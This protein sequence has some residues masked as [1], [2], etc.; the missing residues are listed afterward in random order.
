VAQGA[1]VAVLEPLLVVQFLLQE[2]L[3]RLLD[4]LTVKVTLAAAARAV[5]LIDTEV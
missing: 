3:Q 4:L 2:H 1:V 5:V